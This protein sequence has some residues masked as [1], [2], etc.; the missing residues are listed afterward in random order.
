VW[1]LEDVELTALSVWLWY[2]QCF[3]PKPVS[4]SIRMEKGALDDEEGLYW[5]L[6]A[7]Q[8]NRYFA[9]G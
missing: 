7:I 1:E 4:L 6:D 2:R 8:L 3:R 9:P 5:G